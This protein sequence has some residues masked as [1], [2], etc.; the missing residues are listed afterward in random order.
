[1][2]QSRKAEARARETAEQKLLRLTQIEIPLWAQGF[3]IAGIDEVRSRT[4]GRPGGH[5]L[6]VDSAAIRLVLG[7]DDSKK[8]VRKEARDAVSAAIGGGRSRRN[9]LS[10][11]ADDRRNGH[12]ERH[13]A[14]DGNVC[15]RFSRDF[16]GGRS[17]TNCICRAKHDRSFMATH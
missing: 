5:G 11:P 9:L 15:R 17:E 2:T 7:V 4:A 14:R 1:M 16:S 8:L 6:R 3:A 13:A 10:L 12:S